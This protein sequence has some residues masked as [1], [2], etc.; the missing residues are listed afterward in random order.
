MKKNFQFK[1]ICAGRDYIADNYLDSF[2]LI[3]AAKHSHMSSYH[4]LRTFKNTFG[5]TPNAFLIRLRIEKAKKMLVTENSSIT[6]ICESV[7]YLSL[8]SF[9]SRFREQVGVSPSLYR[10]K[11]WSLSTEAFHYPSQAIPACYAYHFLGTSAM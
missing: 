11:L 8:G 9:S 7:G 10:R 3:G 1:K 5:E 6:E 4:F 2:S